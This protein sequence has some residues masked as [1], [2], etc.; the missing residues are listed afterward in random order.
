MAPFLLM[1]TVMMVTE[2]FVNLELPLLLDPK[3]YNLD[4][5]TAMDWM[6]DETYTGTAPTVITLLIGGYAYDIIGRKWTVCFTFVLTGLALW[7]FPFAAPSKA[8]FLLFSALFMLFMGPMG[9]SPLLM[10]YVC[11]E[12]MGSAVAMRLIGVNIAVIFSNNVLWPLLKP[13]DPVVSWGILAGLFIGFGI[14]AIFIV[15]DVKDL[16]VERALKRDP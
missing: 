6:M 4:N 12:S 11:K 3:Y 5:K 2:V 8:C 16:K 7:G 14:L 13:L 9:D 15:A 10:D 1:L